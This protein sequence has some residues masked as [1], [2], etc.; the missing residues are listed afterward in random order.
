MR[1]RHLL[2]I[3]ILRQGLSGITHASLA[4]DVCQSFSIFHFYRLPTWHFDSPARLIISFR[5]VI[6]RQVRVT[7]GGCRGISPSDVSAC[8][9]SVGD[10]PSLSREAFGPDKRWKF[11]PV[12]QGSYWGTSGSLYSEQGHRIVMPR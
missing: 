11:S 3:R 5:R 8:F 7:S 9:A 6:I 4:G 2:P 10:A 12:G 1:I